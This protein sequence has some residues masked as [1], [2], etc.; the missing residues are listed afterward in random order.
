MLMG[1]VDQKHAFTSAEVAV[2]TQEM[3]QDLAA[4]AWPVNQER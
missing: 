3:Q 2:V 4:D 1:C